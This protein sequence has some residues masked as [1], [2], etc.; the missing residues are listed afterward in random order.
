M[1]ES[2]RASLV[3]ALAATAAAFVA[4]GLVL[5]VAIDTAPFAP[6]RDALEAALGEVEPRTRTLL[7]GITGGSIAGKWVAHLALVGPLARGERWARRATLAGLASWFVL[8]SA[9][10]LAHG[11]WWNVAYVNVVPLVTFGLLAARTKSA[12]TGAPPEIVRG[13]P[14]WWVLLAAAFGATSG[15]VI[16]LGGTTALF[17]AWRAALG[18]AHHGGSLPPAIAQFTATFFGPIGG[19]TFAQF[20]LLGALARERISR[21]DVRAVDWTLASF[22]AWFVPD[23]AWSLTSGGSFN[24]LLV[25]VP[26]AAVLLPPLAWARWKLARSG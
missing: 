22:F 26:F 18:E 23:C 21:G 20:L 4:L 8:D 9:V 3:R 7:L 11:A 19:S 16:A 25:N 2:S 17:A 10:S 14:A 1:A 24:V 5:P 13:S 6:Y 15:L 12:D